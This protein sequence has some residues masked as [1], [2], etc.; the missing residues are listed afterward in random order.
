MR[1]KAGERST[2]VEDPWRVGV[3]RRW[4]A[5]G[6]LALLATS[7]LPM[8]GEPV[9]QTSELLLPDAKQFDHLGSEDGLS[10]V[11]VSAILQDRQ[12]FLWFGTSDGLNR[13]DGYEF[14]IFYHDPDDAKSLS[15]RRIR[16]LYEDP[17]GRLW[18]GTNSSGLD[19]LDPELGHFIHSRHDPD[20]PHSLSHDS[21]LS[22]AP[23]RSGHLWIGTRN[24]LNRLDSTEPWRFTRY[25]QTAGDAEGLSHGRVNAL[26]AD[27]DD[28]LWIA[29]AGGLDR[30]DP[31][32]RK[33]EHFRHDAAD[34]RSLA[35]SVVYA[36]AENEDG[37]L[38]VG[39]ER[40]LDH[41]SREQGF[42]HYQPTPEVPDAPSNAISGIV[43]DTK[44]RWWIATQGGLWLFDPETN[45][46]HP[47][48][49]DHDRSLAKQPISSILVDRSDALWLG[50]WFSG[51][52][53]HDP[54]R[55]HFDH[56]LHDPADPGSLS[57][58][59]VFSFAE[60]REGH[61][62]IGTAAG[63]LNR[64]DATRGNFEH[65]RHDWQDPDSLSG[66]Y[67]RRLLVDRHD[68]L[69]IGTPD[70]GLNRLGPDRQRFVHF[71]HDPKNPASP[72]A[73]S[74][75]ALEEARDG[76]LWIGSYEGLDR[77]DPETGRFEHPDLFGDLAPVG[78]DQ[79]VMSLLE[80]HQGFLWAG[81]QNGLYRY[82][83]QRAIRL[84]HD[85]KDPSSLNNDDVWSLHE[86]PKGLLWIGTGGGGLAR[87]DPSSLTFERFTAKRGLGNN[88][89][90]AILQ[91]DS[92]RLWLS[93]NRGLIR[94]DPRRD[95]WLRYD[96]ADGLQDVEF[97][98]GSALRSRDGTMYFG[99]VRGFNSFDPSRFLDNPWM[100]PVVVTTF[101]VVERG[102]VLPWP[103]VGGETFTLDYDEGFFSFE[104]AALS[105]TRPDKNLYRYRLE[106]VDQDW[107]DAGT[108]RFARYTNVSPGR[109]I[110]RVRGSNNDGVWNTVGASLEIVIVSPWWRTG[111]AY[112]LYGLLFVALITGTVL[113]QRQKLARERAI[114]ERE[115]SISADLEAKNAELER[116]TYTVSHDLKNPL[117]TIKNYLGA[118]RHRLDGLDDERL[119]GDL[120]R[121]ERASSRMQQMIEE[122]LELSRV[123]RVIHPPEEVGFGELAHEA[124][125]H[126][127]NGLA[128]D[129]VEVLVTNDLPTLYGDRLRLLEVLE[130]LIENACK[131]MGDQPEPRIE[132]G[133]RETSGDP[134]LFVRDNGIGIEPRYL[135]RVF[136]LFE[137]LDPT[138]DGTGIGLALAKRI[139]E[140]HDGHCWAES[141][142]PGQGSTFC[143]TLP[144][145][146]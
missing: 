41:F 17:Q 145:M 14:E 97:N 68:N 106:G 89:V 139:I 25:L 80:D 91:D 27:R 33:L 115:R 86:D 69:W 36:L 90:Y 30:L 103:T 13:Y 7:T 49:F 55:P 93:T 51:L 82:D 63:G 46:F 131:F 96:L 43:P 105:Y 35:H 44:G 122:L 62:W 113:T 54:W 53:R 84:A 10:Q 100:P 20:D 112:A 128:R 109:Y 28:A 144:D 143:F 52:Y 120:A 45:R 57:S 123:G 141:A 34:P 5:L 6:A 119:R 134:V 9:W 117:V 135:D 18:V 126:F 142:G 21:V 61:F 8:A 1:N 48:S 73:D 2:G 47:V 71:R 72:R 74:A 129:G 23:D 32:R 39:T 140:A 70:R 138:V 58:D 78:S 92:E 108:R 125:E 67:V 99:G 137:R 133:S 29:T 76:G 66:P 12:G 79:R 124:V 94:F 107:I 24:G 111:W 110:F 50:T 19:L 127:A 85:S 11:S 38:L 64:F 101:D 56:F 136:V 88:S 146:H 31:E 22:I 95:Q 116:F 37:T 81:T 87:L 83:G 118:V 98:L 26:L 104:F 60:D 3:V 59:T 102:D 121:I 77:Y 75:L 40:G 42:V 16:A 132:I 130:I 4:L 15:H 114:A 65:F